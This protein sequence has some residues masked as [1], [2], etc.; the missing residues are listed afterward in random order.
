MGGS[1]L[2][3][4]PLFFGKQYLI[5]N[6]KR[7]KKQMDDTHESST[8][9][10][11]VPKTHMA[12][13]DLSEALGRTMNHQ[14]NKI[15]LTYTVVK[16]NGTLVPFSKERILKAI[17]AA[18]LD[19]KKL[20][21]VEPLPEEIRHPIESIANAV[22]EEVLTKAAIGECLTVEGIQDIVEIKLMEAGHHDVAR[23]YI[24]YRDQHKALREDSTKQIRIMRRDG[25]SFVR[26]N[27]IKIASAIERAFRDTLKIAGPTPDKV[28]DAVNLIT[29]KVVEQAVRLHKAG[30]GIGVENIQ[31]EIE[32]QLMKEGFYRVA[33]D[34]ILYRAKRSEIRLIEA[35]KILQ[36][37]SFEVPP[38]T[39][40]EEEA[41][42]EAGQIFTIIGRDL[43]KYTLS[44]SQLRKK[45]AFASR[46]FEE[47]VSIE[48]LLED[49]ITNFY[50][51]IKEHEVDLSNIMAARTKIESEPAYAKVAAHLLLDMLYRESMRAEASA[52]ELKQIHENYFKEYLKFAI[53]MDRLDPALLGF[54]LDKLAKALDISRDQQF[55]YL[56][57]QTL[58]DRYFIHDN[59]RRLETP[60]IFFMR[61]A[62]GLS[63]LEGRQKNERAIQFYEVLSKFLFTSA[64]PTLFNAGTKHP[65][66]SS[67]YLSTVMDDLS[68]IFK[69]ISDDAQLSKWAGGL[70]NDW[71]NVRAT[72]A[73]I[74]GTNGRSQGVIPF[75]KV[76]NDTAVAVNQGGKEKG[77]CA[78]I[79]RF[80]I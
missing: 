4:D 53:S 74:K 50:D 75:L 22:V 70:G 43:Q 71:T 35:Q 33:K 67:C 40:I 24:I 58:Y 79:L 30:A 27:P 18:F 29:H 15:P 69:T 77:P 13:E 73:F 3:S 66:L 54:D 68:H 63:L 25:V 39:Q 60:Q 16:R 10:E 52:T 7:V 12:L 65:Q 61:V 57:L 26:F 44:R 80:G 21:K 20:G 78:P 1:K 47:S 41:H 72:G 8:A 2:Y 31:D 6:F 11:S 37:P 28:I 38:S 48:T 55:S 76:A 34:F 51:G 32:R 46:G 62:M 5:P 64:T 42:E 17:T 23:D 56:G 19:T 36:A 14:E 49:S 9:L 45:I 59:Q